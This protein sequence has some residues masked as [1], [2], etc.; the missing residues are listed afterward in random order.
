MR[1]KRCLFFFFSSRRRHTRFDCDWVQTCALP[2]SGV[3]FFVWAYAASYGFTC[4]YCLV[5][6]SA[7]GLGRPRVAFDARL[8]VR[9]LR[10]AAPFALGAFLTNLYFRADV[11]ILQ[12]FKP[13]QEVG[14]Y[15][16][17]YKPV[18]AL[19]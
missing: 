8:F 6:I 5:V 13:F 12:H 10:L 15:T 3:A 7:F 4:L 9:W 17:A 19:Q 18:E 16:F 11:T 14:W 1:A 2:I